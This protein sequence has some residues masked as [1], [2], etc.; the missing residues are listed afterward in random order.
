MFRYQVVNRKICNCNGYWEEQAGKPYYITFVGR[1][2][3]EEVIEK[4]PDGDPENTVQY[5]GIDCL[6]HN[7]NITKTA[8][9]HVEL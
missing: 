3:T 4:E 2:V 9:F 8:S 1:V 7:N 6:F 5:D